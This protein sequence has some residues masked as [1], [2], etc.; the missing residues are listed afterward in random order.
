MDEKRYLTKEKYKALEKELHELSTTKREEIAEQ[1]HYA[2]S[3]GD[4]SENAEYSDAREKQAKL[5]DRI[6]E[7]ENVLKNAEIVKKHHTDA[8][9]V[10]SSVTVQKKGSTDKIEYEIVGTEEADMSKNKLSYKSPLGEAM[11]GHKKGESFKF[12]TPK[13]NVEYKVISIK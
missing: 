4:L 9:E 2:K 6:R 1:L 12:T 11:L 10:G 13:G 3:L 8:V 7:L 5:E